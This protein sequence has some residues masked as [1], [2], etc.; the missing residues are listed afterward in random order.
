MAESLGTIPANFTI[1]IDLDGA[2]FCT[3]DTTGKLPITVTGCIS[4]DVP[5]IKMH[6]DEDD[7]RAVLADALRAA[8][9]RM[10]HGDA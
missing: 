8:A 9:D 4:G 6:L 1:R 10:E 5:Q 2:H 3:V 7:V